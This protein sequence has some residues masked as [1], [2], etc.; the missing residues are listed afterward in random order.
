MTKYRAMAIRFH[1]SGLLEDSAVNTWH[2]D[3]DG[4]IEGGDLGEAND[5]ATRLHTFYGT[6]DGYYSSVLT[7]KLQVRVYCLEDPP[8]RVPL[9]VQEWTDMAGTATA[10]PEE[11]ALCLSFQA[12]PAS[13]EIPSRRRGRVFLGPLATTILEVDT[14]NHTRPKPLEVNNILAAAEAMAVSGTAGYPRLAIFSPTSMGTPGATLDDA[15]NDVTS[16]WMD[17]RFDVQR[18]RGPKPS[19]K[20]SLPVS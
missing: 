14:S 6:V 12:T 13:G 16:F 4:T 8:E 11:A 1:K 9:T 2:F 20:I 3:S 10:M 18:R 19:T 5:I 17:D 7:N 15:F